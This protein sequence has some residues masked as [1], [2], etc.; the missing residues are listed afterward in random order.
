MSSKKNKKTKKTKKTKKSSSNKIILAVTLIVIIAAFGL[1][2]S[3]SNSS[4][5][6]STK[7]STEGLSLPNYAYTNQRTLQAYAYATKN[8]KI[9]E[10][11]PCY[12]G[13]GGM[14][15]KSLKNCFLKDN[16]NY[17]EHAS[18]CDI[19]VGE[20]F[21]VKRLQ[22]QGTPLKDIRAIIDEEYSQFGPPTN[23]PLL[24]DTDNSLSSI[25]TK[26]DLSKLS[27]PNNFKSLGDGLKMTPDGV[28]W[29][30]FVNVK[31]VV[32]TDLEQY[33]SDRVEPDGFYGVPIIGMY[34]ADY[35]EN[36]WIELHD[37][38]YND[39]TIQP[40][41][42]EG[43]TNI[44][45]RRPFVFGHTEN[46]NR[47]I[48]LMNKPTKIDTDSAYKTFKP[49]LDKMDDENAGIASVNIEDNEFS[50]ISYFSLKSIGSGKI[51]AEKAY[52]ITNSDAIPMSKY[53]EL[54]DSSHSRGFSQYD[55]QQDEYI[56]IIRMVSDLQTILSE[57][58]NL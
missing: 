18:Y 11:I 37:I 44:I 51:I 17:E 52:H 2:I 8:Q 50:D 28:Y 48:D 14:G 27:L 7:D 57:E 25:K 20:A 41:Q 21:R 40:V 23:T 43:M 19:C 56:L 42:R 31:L 49:L 22:E 58:T 1:V 4:N 12:C 53:N 46:V 16:G 10:N 39:P 34:S 29:A 5:K 6:E 3:S 36:S 13:C 54:K 35:S 32:G 38:G 45:S 26:T 9:L 47:V 24:T 33:A 55:I 15:H 30:Q